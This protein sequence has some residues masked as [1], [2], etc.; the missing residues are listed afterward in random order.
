MML[1]SFSWLYT[2][3]ALYLTGGFF[4][5]KM[6]NESALVAPRTFSEA[7]EGCSGGEEDLDDGW[8]WWR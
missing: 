4:S 5:E 8:R 7:I 6:K 1:G 2:F 3:L